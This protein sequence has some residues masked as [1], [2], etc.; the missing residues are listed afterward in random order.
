MNN[1]G[2]MSGKNVS[3][4]PF[5]EALAQL[6][7]HVRQMET[8]SV[9]LEQM[10]RRY[11]EAQKLAAACRTKLENMKKKIEVLSKAGGKVRWRESSD[12]EGDEAS[13]APA[14]DFFPGISD[15]DSST[16]L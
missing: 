14:D 16:T 13:A 3:D 5:E 4:M 10:I 2:E 12:E 7:E 6:E 1:E 9:P 11:E 8:G 15:G